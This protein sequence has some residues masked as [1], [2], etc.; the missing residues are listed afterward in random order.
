MIVEDGGAIHRMNVTSRA[1][2]LLLQNEAMDID[3]LS[4]TLAEFFM[5]VSREQVSKDMSLLLGQFWA[6]GLIEP[7]VC[8]R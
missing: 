5:P 7:V 1:V 4:K 8:P 3:E 2:W 6:V